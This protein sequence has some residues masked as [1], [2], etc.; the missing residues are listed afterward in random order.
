M[1]TTWSTQRLVAKSLS[2][3]YLDDLHLLHSDA[4]V[5]AIL[6]PDGGR[7]PRRKTEE[8][9]ANAQ[10][11]WQQYGYGFWMFYRKESGEF[12]GR[13]GIKNYRAADLQ[14]KNVNGIAYATLSS[15]WRKGY[16]QEMCEGILKIAFNQ[17]KLETLSGWALPDNMASIKL[18]EKLR[19]QFQ[20]SIS[21][22]DLPHSYYE[23]KRSH[24]QASC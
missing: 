2:V 20:R 22:A 24:F 23:L 15:L 11:H 6:N 5:M 1:L 3:K 16:A 10:Q 17:L 21:F 13:S 18:L 4:H 9:V 7:L 19:F 14:G 8:M 12:I